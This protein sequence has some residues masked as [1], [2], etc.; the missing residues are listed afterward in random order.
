MAADLGFANP[1]IGDITVLGEGKPL[2]FILEDFPLPLVWR[3][4]HKRKPLGA[5]WPC[6]NKFQIVIGE[7]N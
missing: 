7:G 5:F 3:L 1:T 2:D 6:V 4:C